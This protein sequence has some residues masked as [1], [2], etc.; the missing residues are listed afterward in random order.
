TRQLAL[1]RHLAAGHLRAEPQ[2][3]G[4]EVA[5]VLPQVGVVA[6]DHGGQIEVAVLPESDGPEEL[7]AKH[8]GPRLGAARDAPESGRDPDGVDRVA[9]RLAHLLPAER[10]E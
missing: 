7:V 1:P 2:R 6:L 10:E 4:E 8:V 9:E 3:A 5:E